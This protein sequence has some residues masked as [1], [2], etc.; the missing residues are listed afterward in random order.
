MGCIYTYKGVNFDDEASLDEFLELESRATK[1]TLTS[2]ELK[3]LSM[4]MAYKMVFEGATIGGIQQPV[5][6]KRLQRDK[7]YEMIQ[8]AHF[9]GLINASKHG[10]KKALYENAEIANEYLWE[11][12]VDFL[13][14]LG[15]SEI[16]K[17]EEES[18]EPAT[19]EKGSFVP[20]NVFDLSAKKNARA[21]IKL[22]LALQRSAE[23][24]DITGEKGF[25]KFNE[26]WSIMSELYGTT[27]SSTAT[28]VENMITKLKAIN[29]TRKTSFIP[30][31]INKLE[32][33]PLFRSQLVNTFGGTVNIFINTDL[34]RDDNGMISANI[35]N[36]NVNTVANSVATKI[37]ANMLSVMTETEGDED[38]R[39]L[40][41]S[42]T[43]STMIGNIMDFLDGNQKP[44]YANT[45]ESRDEIIGEILNLV[46]GV[47]PLTR[48]MLMEKAINGNT[49]KA[50][51]GLIVQYFSNHVKSIFGEYKGRDKAISSSSEMFKA[52]LIDEA[53]IA[54]TKT[55]KI[56]KAG[57]SR[58]LFEGR[59][60]SF[61]KE[62]GKSYASRY[63]VP[64]ESS[65]L[66]RDG[67]K[68][69]HTQHNFMTKLVDKFRLD[70]DK[71]RAEMK[72]DL[73]A[74][75]SAL[76][77][78]VNGK[79]RIEN[80]EVVLLNRVAL[81][82]KEAE[83][84][85]LDIRDD[86]TDRILRTLDPTNPIIT[87]LNYS[88]KSQSYGLRGFKNQAIT[89]DVK[90]NPTTGKIDVNNYNDASIESLSR[91]F[92][93]EY[94]R[95]VLM[96]QAMR[97]DPKF[98]VISTYN[99][100]SK[101]FVLFEDITP[102]NDRPG[103]A[104][105]ALIEAIYSKGS[106]QILENFECEAP[107]NKELIEAY[108][109]ELLKSK[110][111][112]GL[113]DMLKVGVVSIN[114][115]AKGVPSLTTQIKYKNLAD[116][117]IE[118]VEGLVSAF[119]T[120]SYLGNIEF[121]KLLTGDLAFYKSFDEL[122]KR[123]A[124]LIAPGTDT[125]V[126]RG[127][128]NFTMATC[129]DIDYNMQEA[130]PAAYAALY[131]AT[132]ERYDK[133]NNE[134]RAKGLKE[135]TADEIAKAIET[136][137]K[138]Y[139]GV[140]LAD[141][142]AII[143][144]E[145]WKQIMIQNSHFD[146]KHEAIY[147]KAMRKEVLTYGEM[148]ALQPIKGMYF[149][150]VIV[151]VKGKVI[152]VPTYTKCSQLPNF[153]YI[154]E[155]NPVMTEVAQK[156]KDSGVDELHMSSS[157][158]LGAQNIV[159]MQGGDAY[160]AVSVPASDYKIQQEMPSHY[161][162][163][164]E[165]GKGTQMHKIITLNLSDSLVFNFKQREAV[166]KPAVLDENGAI[167]TPEVVSFVESEGKQ[168]TT[169]QLINE[170]EKTDEALS[171][172]GIEKLKRRIG[173]S[174][175]ETEDG[176]E[177]KPTAAFYQ[178][179][180]ENLE[181]EATDTVIEALSL[182][183][184][185]D[186]IPAYRDKIMS[187][188]S[189]EVR[190]AATR[191]KINGSSFIQTSS[192]TIG[193]IT[194]EKLNKLDGVIYFPDDRGEFTGLRGPILKDGMVHGAQ[195]MLPYKAGQKAI[196]LFKARNN[197][198]T[199]SPLQLKEMLK[200]AGLIDG[201]V[202][203]RIPT[204]AHASIDSLEVAG[205]LPESMGDTIYVYAENPGKTGADFDIDKM[206]VMMPEMMVND[207]RLIAVPTSDSYKQ[208]LHDKI[209]KVLSDIKG[210]ED[211][212]DAGPMKKRMNAINRKLF[213]EK[214]DE[215]RELEASVHKNK[216]LELYNMILR[217]PDLYAQNMKS[218][219]TTVLKDD[220]MY[221]RLLK[222]KLATSKD[223]SATLEEMKVL[224][225]D[226][227]AFKDAIAKHNAK[228]LGSLGMLD[229]ME[230]LFA[231]HE[232]AGGATGI[233][234]WA[235]HSTSHSVCQ[236][237]KLMR[238]SFLANHPL[239]NNV[240][241]NLSLY[242][243]YNNRGE[244]I[245]DNIMAFLNANLDVA[246][247]AY[248]GDVNSNSVT[249]NIAAL[250]MR[251]GF[252]ISFI[253]RL[254]VQP[255]IVDFVNMKLRAQSMTSAFDT[256]EG[257][258]DKLRGDTPVAKLEDVNLFFNNLTDESLEGL[259]AKR[260]PISDSK[261]L[262]IFYNLLAEGKAMGDVTT[263][264]KFDVDGF[265]RNFLAGIISKNKAARIAN[266]DNWININNI[267]SKKV[268]KD[269]KEVEVKTS[270]GVARENTLTFAENTIF[271][272]IA[273][274]S[275]DSV[276]LYEEVF[277]ALGKTDKNGNALMDLP[278][279]TLI[280]K[281]LYSFMMSK[282]GHRSEK[283]T[284]KPLAITELTRLTNPDTV[285]G[286]Y[287]WIKAQKE[288]SV[289]N[290]NFTRALAVKPVFVNDK[291]SS[292]Y[293]ILDT[294]RRDNIDNNYFVNN[295]NEMIRETKITGDP[296]ATKMVNDIIKLGHI[297]GGYHLTMKGYFTVLPTEVLSGT[298]S[299]VEYIN[300]MGTIEHKE[301]TRFIRQFIGNASSSI[302]GMKS[303]TMKPDD[304][305]NEDGSFFIKLYD[306]QYAQYVKV[307][308]GKTTTVCELINATPVSKDESTYIAVPVTQLG[309]NNRD[310]KLP[311]YDR[312]YDLDDNVNSPVASTS[313]AKGS[314]PPVVVSL[315]KGSVVTE[316]PLKGDAEINV[317][318]GDTEVVL[319]YIKEKGSIVTMN[320]KDVATSESLN[321]GSLQEVIKLLPL[322]LRSF[323]ENANTLLKNNC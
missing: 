204:Q 178:F 177:F 318:V 252:P 145:R 167:L 30:E 44:N 118:S 249:A 280:E 31:I 292:A 89:T 285:S 181:D 224:K 233:G 273:T 50:Q 217:S 43:G 72:E 141:G 124:G 322:Y 157:T 225:A 189:S 297:V 208:H 125:N 283:D 142:L 263:V 47:I 120:A 19:D 34:V 90:F 206:Y 100:K 265:G 8:R 219:D 146:A 152:K 53:S 57:L 307:K 83:F 300:N 35:Y 37:K 301:M 33:D 256:D 290:N 247:D 287:K 104:A 150:H 105:K 127:D 154:Q 270:M 40:V 264:Y 199:P 113:A 185:L 192:A 139:R 58:D 123:M 201:L 312:S 258:T 272:T 257:I 276:T 253:N 56:N 131:D 138:P 197:G 151:K 1:E 12:T 38:D 92:K 269:G 134:L 52:Y 184:S 171:N 63:Y 11:A 182:G 81:D 317:K 304:V 209:Q 293:L 320:G 221:L 255:I 27:E 143:S 306:A 250:M 216:Y 21:E 9:L 187:V 260:D 188:L 232:F 214:L 205:I 203:Y 28:V 175:N 99:T 215:L 298:G 96:T 87:G 242:G 229:P 14:G 49:P 170:L 271:K 97:E 3:A 299:E 295:I 231:K 220:A 286:I 62:I 103:P 16:K 67:V 93:T 68:Y 76:L 196:E 240:D 155:G 282:I 296:V 7:G 238:K 69:V 278:L 294:P 29:L 200:E 237:A 39:R 65:V 4:L 126:A 236:K 173:L 218:L 180:R 54:T 84:S 129:N 137:I 165:S 248:T 136:D 114:N 172:M 284:E 194:Q 162:T 149:S 158:K 109:K 156:M 60:S 303:V 243:A 210:V 132:V 106:K 228:K 281:N 59:N 112:K 26:V 42:K 98:A 191:V 64:G 234:I 251:G 6:P 111:N 133:I 78:T 2:D 71:L 108:M 70:P 66:T 309:I 122:K 235:N 25:V 212:P 144:P 20:G 73:Y 51:T 259:L 24:D 279:L 116:K 176:S 22:M 117:E 193:K 94:D 289:Y 48:E 161:M 244:I 246:K 82:G 61:L 305:K 198:A 254:M 211:A 313:K 15:I 261:L 245:S 115:D 102:D 5:N 183:R 227:K 80:I 10:D 241:G 319:K 239:A 121:S 274:F 85:D 77:N 74:S 130:N 226:P 95:I 36:A 266:D 190:K 55:G 75:D 262:S 302:Q 160:Y 174:I 41:L 213:Y 195:V 267:I 168:F 79:Y 110:I 315:V 308:H 128:E 164:G 291:V 163:D 316:G 153:P 311:F 23:T 101:E 13:D 186:S 321:A 314:L 148:K 88:D 45:E 166:V 222:A 46:D 140:N 107:Q 147:E 323:G 202:G 268:I 277:K 119:I 32:K 159:N 169:A 207:G 275:N 230:Q 310:I 86:V 17:V 18:V 223:V 288:D 179:L 135:L 91:N